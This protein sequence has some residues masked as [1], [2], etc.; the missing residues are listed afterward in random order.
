MFQVAH[1]PFHWVCQSGAETINNDIGE[2]MSCDKRNGYRFSLISGT[3]FQ[4][5]KYPLK[6]WFQVA[7]LMMQS[8]KGM[9]AM[10]VQRIHLRQF[11]Q[12]AWYMCHRVRAAIKHDSFGC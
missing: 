6:T 2:L 3:V 1:R 7:F 11:L 12:D 10:Q 4:D 5:T 9:S 8:K